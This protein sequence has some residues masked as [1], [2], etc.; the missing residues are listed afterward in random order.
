MAGP[1]EAT[2]LGNFMAQLMAFGEVQSPSE[3]REIVRRSFDTVTYTPGDGAA[4]DEAYGRFNL[5]NR[6]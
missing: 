5:V 6:S 4:W 3:V 2:A 1:A